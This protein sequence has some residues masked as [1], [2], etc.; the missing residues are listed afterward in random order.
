M[1][2]PSYDA[3]VVGS[4]PNGLAAAIEIARTGKSVLVLEAADTIG[5]G[6]RSAPLTDP[7]YVHDVCSA[8]HP[9]G[10]ASP[11]FRTLPLDIDWIHPD[12]AAAHPMD[13]GTAVTLSRSIS[14]T[15]AGL[16]DDAT[17]YVKLMGR[18]V[19]NADKIIPA[20]QGPVIPIPKHPL[21]VTRFGML[22]ARSALS[23]AKALLRTNRARALIAGTAA[24]PMLPLRTLP[25]HGV[26]LLFHLCA[27]TTGWPFPRGG[28]QAIPDA[29]AKYLRSLGGEIECGR[30]VASLRDVPSSRAVLFDLTPRQIVDIAGEELPR[31]YR[32][33]L[34]RFKYGPGVF[35][36]DY[37]L[38]E[39]VPWKAAECTRAGTVH[40]GGTYEEIAASEAAVAMGRH[41]DRPWVIVAQQ[42]VFDETRAPRGKQTLWTYCHVPSGSTVDMTECLENQIERFAPGFRDTIVARSVKT[43]ADLEAYNENYIG[44]DIAGGLSNLRQFF[45]RPIV[46][47]NPY[48][49]PN[50]RLFIC[51]SSTPPGAGVHGMCGYHAARSALKTLA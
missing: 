47:V 12:F 31:L 3:V 15:A 23:N 11:Y 18:L 46:K 4:G 35:K 25:A 37:A 50:P 8:I 2:G 20:L 22:T 1:S 48:A 39:P 17:R 33:R 7:G 26:W 10:A 44:G 32:R 49:T 5:G 34:S 43:P 36:V 9:T 24:H 38:S 40:L 13:D 21:L 28:S 42:S 45:T 6:C 27:H 29:L 19:E 14:D 30:R 16:G 51:S 41:P